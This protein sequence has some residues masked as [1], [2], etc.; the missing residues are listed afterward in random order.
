MVEPADLELNVLDFNRK[1]FSFER[2]IDWDGEPIALFTRRET[3]SESRFRPKVIRLQVALPVAWIAYDLAADLL[4]PAKD[5]KPGASPPKGEAL[6]A[7][8]QPT[9]FEERGIAWRRHAEADGG[10]LYVPEPWADRLLSPDGLS[11]LRAP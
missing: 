5:G 3:E 8:A 2:T 1:S 11:R 4:V 10:F 9:R 7:A 6:E